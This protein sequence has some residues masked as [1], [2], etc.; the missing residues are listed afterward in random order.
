MNVVRSLAET[1]VYPLGECAVMETLGGLMG[2]EGSCWLS[3]DVM[4]CTCCA[5]DN[6]ELFQFAMAFITIIFFLLVDRRS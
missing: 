6:M 5:L 3:R 2:A 1:S 4:L